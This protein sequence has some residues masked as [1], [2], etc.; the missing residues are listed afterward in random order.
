MFVLWLI[1]V[2]IGHSTAFQRNGF[3]VSPKLSRIDSVGKD[4]ALLIPRHLLN[5]FS[6]PRPDIEAVEASKRYCLGARKAVQLLLLA[7]MK[8]QVYHIARLV[9]RASICA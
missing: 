5:E 1:K 4:E 2:H 9:G 8:W 7:I 3:I 6:E